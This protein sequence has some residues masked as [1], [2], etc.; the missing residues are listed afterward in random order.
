MP[1]MQ[2]TQF[3]IPIPKRPQVLVIDTE[4]LKLLV[5]FYGAF[6]PCLGLFEAARHAGI[7][8]KA[9]SITALS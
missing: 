4:L 3:S 5:L 9:N 8:C 1:L 7:A 6:E 2:S